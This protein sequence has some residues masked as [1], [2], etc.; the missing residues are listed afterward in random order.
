[1]QVPRLR[2]PLVLVHGLLGFDERRI[3]PWVWA[4]FRK[5]PAVLQSAG[6]R[7]LV[8]V[9]SRTDSIV[10]RATQLRDFLDRH[11][12]D[13]KVHLIAHSMGGLDSRYLITHLKGADRVLSLT[14]VGTPHRGT[15]FADR[16]LSALGPVLRPLFDTL[17]LPC[18]AFYDLTRPNC[19]KFNDV[20]PDMPGVRYF[21][22]AGRYRTRWA[23]PHW[24]LPAWVVR[25]HEGD[26]DG[27]VSVDSAKWGES[28]EVWDGDHLH[29]VN[30]PALIS[31]GGEDRIA[32]WVELVQRLAD[33]GF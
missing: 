13:E 19:R 15:A 26:N 28:C 24:W 4:Y 14:T 23:H 11:C 25:N 20:T 9:L 31:S 2:N 1:M 21:S 33:A 17:R 7:V 6:N 5:I 18:Q 29:L 12:P 10:R 3:G 27:I 32:R 30:W 16:G 22:V 8:P